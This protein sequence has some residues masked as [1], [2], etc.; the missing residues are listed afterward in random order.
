MAT[1]KVLSIKFTGDGRQLAQEAQRVQKSLAELGKTAEAKIDR[2]QTQ[3]L[4]LRSLANE[5]LTIQADHA[6]LISLNEVIGVTIARLKQLK[7][8]TARIIPVPLRTPRAP[9]T[10]PAAISTD[11][12]S[13]VAFLK[14]EAQAAKEAEA[15]RK[16][17]NDEA[18]RQFKY[19]S[20]RSQQQVKEALQAESAAMKDLA[21]QAREADKALQMERANSLQGR[22]A[23]TLRDTAAAGGTL[24][25]FGLAFEALRLP[26]QVLD[27][28]QQMEALRT[29]INFIEGGSQAGAESL[30]FINAEV[31]R[32]SLPLK[33]STDNFT[34]LAAAAR[35]TELEGEGVK[36]IFTGIAQASRVLNLDTQKQEK[37]FL[38]VQQSISKGLVQQEELRGQ[39]SEALPNAIQVFAR[40]LGVSTSRLQE[41]VKAGEVGLPEIRKFVLQLTK[42]T[43]SGVEKA[44]ESSLAA[45]A[46]LQTQFQRSAE[47]IGNLALPL[48][49]ASIDSLTASLKFLSENADLFG[50]VATVLAA[51]QLPKLISAIKGAE[52][53]Q[54]AYAVATKTATFEQEFQIASQ[55]QQLL[56]LAG[57]AAKLG[58]AVAALEALKAAYSSVNGEGVEFDKGLREAAQEIKRLKQEAGRPVDDDFGIGDAANEAAGALARLDFTG[59]T[60]GVQKFYVEVQQAFLGGKDSADKFGN[61]LGFITTQQYNNQQAAIALADTQAAL[62]QTFSEGTNLALKLARGE[63]VNQ[64]QLDLTKQSLTAY[65]DKLKAAPDAQKRLNPAIGLTI[66]QLEA[67]INKLNGGG[68]ATDAIGENTDAVKEQAKAYDAATDAI[69]TRGELQQAVIERRVAQGL[70]TEQ[71]GREQTLQNEKQLTAQ[72]VA[73]AQKRATELAA[74]PTTK[75]FTEQDKLSAIAKVELDAAKLQADLAKKEADSRKQV[76]EARLKKQKEAEQKRLDSVRETETNLLALVKSAEQQRTIEV[77]QALNKGLITEQQAQAYKLNIVRSRLQ[78]ELRENQA[79][80]ARLAALPKASD[81][82]LEK[83]RQAEIRE[84]RAQTSELVLQVAQNETERQKELQA[85]LIK[86]IED[87]AD[88]E[89]N[90]SDRAVAGLEKEKAAQELILASLERQNKL[91]ESRV[92]LQKAVSDLATTRTQIELDNLTRAGEIRKQLNDKELKSAAVRYQL[93]QELAELTGSSDTT[94]LQILQQRQALEDQLAE[95]KMAALKAEQAQ[96]RA[97]LEF[98]IKRNQLVAERAVLEARIAAIQAKTKIA[99]AQFEL[100]KAQLDGDK[101]K[102]ANAK[103]LVDLARQQ[104]ELSKGLVKSAQEEASQQQELASNQR[105]TLQL[106]QQAATET[107]QAADR[108]RNRAQDEE[109]LKAGGQVAPKAKQYVD[110]GQFIKDALKTGGVIQ[111]PSPQKP[112]PQSVLPENI[113]KEIARQINVAQRPIQVSLVQNF[114]PSERGQVANRTREEVLGV[115]GEVLNA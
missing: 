81:P 49:N 34:K 28:T 27:I 71:Q 51:S 8:E 95:Q 36:E 2:G 91:L 98:D 22:L 93:Q 80:I 66:K 90:R 18:E 76:T 104:Y 19:N 56:N 50:S 97:N 102:I 35:G 78:S 25:A 9:S 20:A 52:I 92:A 1:E 42:E 109:L 115:L 15:A 43:A 100:Q 59:Y 38:A 54:A 45:S 13:Q 61:S 85:Q 33:E 73:E 110:L 47:A 7:A 10:T 37:A 21:Q 74:I 39:L 82:E 11:G 108:L 14:A 26:S 31:D 83:Q 70:L 63:Q 46:R 96:Q 30:Q 32:L 89:K 65:L 84:A 67:L 87:R 112:Q 114:D 79:H 24:V 4:N 99:E 41:M 12:Q 29:S 58:L 40:A 17:L 94:S 86:G 53:A 3:L 106:Q 6:D 113:G 60:Q 5:R 77:Q 88:Q 72:L 75:D 107:E 57:L 55:K 48:I 16:R 44:S 69:K 64:Q 23:Q 103:Q 111:L 105:Q 101:Q 68:G 62:G